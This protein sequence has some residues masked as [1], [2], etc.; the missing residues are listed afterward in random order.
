MASGQFYDSTYIDNLTEVVLPSTYL[1]LFGNA[2]LTGS[3]VDNAPTVTLT[4][5]WGIDA[6]G[7]P[8]FDSAG[9]APGEAAYPSVGANGEIVLTLLVADPTIDASG[10]FGSAAVVA[11]PTL[12]QL[13]GGT[14][15]VWFETNGDGVVLDILS[16]VA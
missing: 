2:Q 9:A 3:L 4:S 15:F 10:I 12:T 14:E 13:A 16:G 5:P 6:D 1:P 8:Y 7:N 11:G